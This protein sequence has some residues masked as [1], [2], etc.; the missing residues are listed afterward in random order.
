[1]KVC[2]GVAGQAAI[3]LL[4]GPS[5]A[6]PCCLLYTFTTPL[7]EPVAN[8]RPELEH[9]R[10]VLF[11]HPSSTCLLTQRRMRRSQVCT[12]PSPPTL[13]PMV[14]YWCARNIRNMDETHTFNAQVT[15]AELGLV[16]WVPWNNWIA[17]LCGVLSSCTQSKNSE[18]HAVVLCPS[19]LVHCIK[20]HSGNIIQ[21]CKQYSST[22]QWGEYGGPDAEHS[23]SAS[24]HSSSK[25]SWQATRD[26][27]RQKQQEFQHL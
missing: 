11:R 14:R 8:R 15:T 1:M 7:L 21:Q 12:T 10:A 25:S 20:Q 5:A 26:F 4:I 27:W 6:G 13:P 24:K 22:K 16:I 17:H 3:G 18:L 2:R 23:G 19:C 9:V